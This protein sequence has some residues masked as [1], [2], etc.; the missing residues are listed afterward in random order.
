VRTP[1]GAGVGGTLASMGLAV[2]GALI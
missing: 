1:G 2:A